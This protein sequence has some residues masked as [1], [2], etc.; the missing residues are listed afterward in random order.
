MAE[1]LVVTWAE[2]VLKALIGKL[3]VLLLKEFEL[4]TEVEAEVKILINELDGLQSFLRSISMSEDKNETTKTWMKQ[5]RELGYD[6]ED[7]IDQFLHQMRSNYPREPIIDHEVHRGASPWE[8]FRDALGDVIECAKQLVCDMWNCRCCQFTY[9]KELS[10]RRKLAT[11]IQDLHKRADVLYKRRISFGVQIEGNEQ[12]VTESYIGPG[13]NF[14][15]VTTDNNLLAETDERAE[16]L[17]EC[18]NSNSTGTRRVIAVFGLGGVGKTTLAKQVYEDPSIKSNYDRRAFLTVSQRLD[19]DRLLTDLLVQLEK[20]FKADGKDLTRES[21]AKLEGSKYLIVLDDVWFVNDWESLN[22]HFPEGQIGS[23]IVITTRIEAVANSCC[24]GIE[25][26]FEIKPLSDKK[27]A[28]LFWNMLGYSSDSSGAS[29]SSYTRVALASS[30]ADTKGHHGSTQV[31]NSKTASS[32]DWSGAN[33]GSNSEIVA[34]EAENLGGN[35]TNTIVVLN[36]KPVQLDE[37]GNN[38]IKKCGGMPLAIIYIAKALSSKQQTKDEWSKFFNSMGSQLEYH[39]SL[40]GLKQIVNLSFN[41][42]PY[43]LKSCLLYL[44]IFPEDYEIRRKNLVRRWVAE[45]FV[46][47]RRG[48]TAEE[49]SES[50]FEELVSRSII[51]RAHVSYSGKIKTCRVHDIMLEVIL[52]KSIEENFITIIGES[53]LEVQQVTIRRLAAHYISKKEHARVVGSL[54]QVRSFTAFGNVD[55]YISFFTFELLRVLD[56]EG[57]KGLKGASLDNICKLF[58]LKFLSLRATDINSLPKNIGDLSVLE[59]LD[60]RQTMVTKVPDGISNL[61]H[62]LHLLA[63]SKRTGSGD[64]YRYFTSHVQMPN[65]FHLMES[66]QTLSLIRMPEYT[67]A[68]SFPQNLSKFGVCILDHNEE[69]NQESGNRSKP[70]KIR[71]NSPISANNNAFEAELWN[72][73]KRLRSLTISGETSNVELNFLTRINDESPL[74]LKTLELRGFLGALPGWIKQLQNVTEITLCYSMLEWGP[75]MEI[76]K[77]LTNL[78]SLI[79]QPLSVIT[80]DIDEN[81]I[82]RL[83]EEFRVPPGFRAL[84]TF[85]IDGSK[86]PALVFERACMPRLEM[87]ELSIDFMVNISGLENLENLKELFLQGPD[88]ENFTK[89]VGTVEKAVKECKKMPSITV[90]KY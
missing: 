81:G 80:E 45:G 32:G 74:P 73:V 57:C 11:R 2:G 85:V 22:R 27:S 37:V 14:P 33:T 46:T 67:G 52:S 40:H 62:L 90:V 13:S 76:L 9:C 71:Q 64:N 47:S 66:I 55:K 5:A 1:A 49:V 28:K 43:H 87:I 42:L 34:E 38:I 65:Q 63:G 72:L 41:H 48:M 29:T 60:I 84:K 24:S 59:T 78:Q 26:I 88:N 10:L 70:T 17:M 7:C 35:S 69:N 86:Y 23:R 53:F 51:Q 16:K 82:V 54:S 6:A 30:S 36:E 18:L 12:V 56:L 19:P 79:L 75:T 20:D 4:F 3:A 25:D 8:K 15:Y 58:L 39:P 50:Y 21:H 89:T 61:R 44:S 83:K 77:E 31:M 68:V